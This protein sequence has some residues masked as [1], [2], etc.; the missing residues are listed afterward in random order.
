M[1]AALDLE[2]VAEAEPRPSP[3]LRRLLA[4]LALTMQIPLGLALAGLL[5]SHWDNEMDHAMDAMRVTTTVLADS[6][7]ARLGRGASAD[8]LDAQP[9]ARELERLFGGVDLRD[10]WTAGFVD[11]RGTVVAHSAAPARAGTPVPPSFVAPNRASAPGSLQWTASDGKAM[12]T[13]HA[14]SPVHGWTTFVTVPRAV[15]LAPVWQAAGRLFLGLCLLMAPGIWLAVRFSQRIVRSVDA[16]Q[17][18]AHAAIRHSEQQ[19]AAVLRTAGNAIIVTDSAHRIVIFNDAA[20]AMFGRPKAGMKGQP[21]DLLFT[22]RSWAHF[23]RRCAAGGSRQAGAASAALPVRGVCLRADGATFPAELLVA[24]W[25]DPAGE[26]S[27]TVILRDIRDRLRSRQSLLAAHRDLQRMNDSFQRTLLKEMDLRMTGIARE[28]HDGVGST[29]A[30]I[31]L[32]AASGR[33]TADDP[34]LVL[35]LEKVQEQVHAASESV[36]QL[37]RG[38]LPAGTQAGALLEALEQFAHGIGAA[39]EIRCSVRSRGSFE[40]TAPEVGGHVYRVVQEATTNALR[41][42]KARRVT[43]LLA[44]VGERCR[45]TVVDDG[46]GCDLGRLP[47]FHAGMGMK[48]MRARAAAIDGRLHVQSRPGGGCRVALEWPSKR[49]ST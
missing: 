15:L 10:G 1:S 40:G 16:L 47:A 21:L 11:E 8:G 33:S 30:G 19:L 27:C 44:Q 24:W 43:V 13:Y 17:R 37:S 6:L 35:L 42:G 41:H 22:P 31:S 20:E 29:L 2:R 39:E 48:S 4:R 7:D 14:G 9:Q 46:S 28:L 32:L 18:E 38:I 3:T 34:R 45:V 49:G 5:V 12:L 26:R 23:S 36:R 25:R